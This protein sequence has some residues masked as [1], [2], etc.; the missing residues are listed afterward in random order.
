M[1]FRRTTLKNMKNRGQVI[2][3]TAFT[4]GMVSTEFH[5]EKREVNP[6]TKAKQSQLKYKTGHAIAD[7]QHKE[8]RIYILNGALI[9]FMPGGG[10]N[11]EGEKFFIDGCNNYATNA[12]SHYLGTALLAQECYN[13]PKGELMKYFG[14]IDF[15]Q[16]FIDSNQAK[17]F[18]TAAD[19]IEILYEEKVLEQEFTELSSEDFLKM[20]FMQKATETN[21]AIDITG[22]V[23]RDYQFVDDGKYFPQGCVEAAVLPKKKNPKKRKSA[24]LKAK[25]Y[26]GLQTFT[27]EEIAEMPL[28]LRNGYQ[29]AQN[30]FEK[31]KDFFDKQDWQL[32]DGI[33]CGDIHSISFT[34]PAG[35]GKTTKIRSL[36]GALGMPFVL[37]GGSANIEEADLLGMRNVEAQDGVSVTTWTD[38]PITSAIRYGAFLLFDEVNSADPGIL[39]KLNTILDGSK[40]MLLS[41]SEEVRVHPKFVYSE[42]MNIGVGYAGTDQMNQSHF[43]RCDEMFKIAAASPEREAE[44]LSKETGYTNMHNL[45]EMCRI[46]NYILELIDSQGDAAEQICSI[47][48]LIAWVKKARRIGDFVEASLTTVLA[49]LCVYDD[50]LKVL[51]KAEIRESSGIASA[52]LERIEDVFDGEIVDINEFKN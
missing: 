3:G 14:M 15:S 8:E 9:A 31:N 21:K 49:H 11:P 30:A 46:K 25:Y 5:S 36:A 37:V 34:G 48:R 40:S 33:A 24:D 18:L 12:Y 51:S 22:F 28:L 50:S 20:P 27:P 6:I 19:C 7:S 17:A 10:K 41:T 26:G 32:V 16:E 43:D 42:A 47:R 39:M 45:V 1:I 29:D 44:I 52:V 2:P 38:G 4:V 35:V 13:N 23:L